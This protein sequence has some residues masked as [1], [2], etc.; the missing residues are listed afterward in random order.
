[1]L[2]PAPAVVLGALVL[3][4]GAPDEVPVAEVGAVVLDGGAA[5]VEPPVILPAELQAMEEGIV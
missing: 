5:L 1:M 3:D 4:R 2:V